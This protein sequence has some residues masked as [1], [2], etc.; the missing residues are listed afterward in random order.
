MHDFGG[1][2]WQGHSAVLVLLGDEGEDVSELGEGP[3]PR[4]HQRVAA[5]DGGD[6]RHPCPIVLPVK[7]DLLVVK[8]HGAIMRLAGPERT[9]QVVPGI[10]ANSR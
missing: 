7:Y 2:E 9:T 10:S 5:S 6:L 3:L 8:A 4:V 1:V